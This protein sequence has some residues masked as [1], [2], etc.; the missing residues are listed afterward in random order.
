MVTSLCL[1][2]DGIVH[3]VLHG[4]VERT[5][6]IT[7]FVVV[8]TALGVDICNLLIVTSFGG[9]YLTDA[10]EQF[11]KVVFAED[12]LAFQSF[13]IEC[14]SLDNVFLQYFCRPNAKLCGLVTIYPISY[15]YHNI[16]IIKRH[17]LFV[18]L[19]RRNQNFSNCIG[20]MDFSGFINLFQVITYKTYLSAEWQTS[21]P[22]RGHLS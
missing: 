22:I 18:P 6:D 21:P 1:M 14:K 12:S 20:Q 10:V 13:I 11:V 5:G 8:V 7:V 19:F 16:K 9:A 2:G 17:S 15:C 3:H 4:L